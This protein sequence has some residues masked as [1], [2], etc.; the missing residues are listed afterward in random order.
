VIAEILARVELKPVAGYTA[1][2]TR[3][4][5]AFAPSDGLPVIAT[6]RF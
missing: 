3:K 1:H 6:N 5:I 2:T 4:G